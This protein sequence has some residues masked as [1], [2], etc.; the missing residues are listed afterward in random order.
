MTLTEEL[1][2]AHSIFIDTA[3]IIYYIE[4]HQR[5]GPIVREVVR[6]FHTGALYAYSSVLT[7]TEVL[8]K[9]I[10]ADD[11][12]MARKFAEFLEYGKNF[13]L[14]EISTDIAKRAGRLRGKYLRLRTVDA[15]QVS[16]ALDVGA[17][18]FVTH[19]TNL[20]QVKEIK[21]VILEDYL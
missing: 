8:P 1:T 15:V 7:L 14:V 20:R 2:Q 18:L 19:D 11:E 13:S 4:G 12:N 6:S 16:T 10:E 21:A 9:P 5:Y 3:P 17:D